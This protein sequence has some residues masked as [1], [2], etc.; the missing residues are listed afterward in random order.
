VGKGGSRGKGGEMSQTLYAHLNKITIQKTKTKK[1]CNG[2]GCRASVQAPVQQ[3][4][5]KVR[6]L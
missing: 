5:K 2:L 3:Q 6:N 1:G 4:Q